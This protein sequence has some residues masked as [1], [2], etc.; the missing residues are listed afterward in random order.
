M[1]ALRMAYSIFKDKKYLDFYKKIEHYCEE[2]FVDSQ[3]GEWYG[4]LH[5]DNTVST[6]LK[7]NI[8]K[9]PFHVPRMYM[10]MCELDETGTI[11][12]YVK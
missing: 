7:G 2:C 9:G 8:F 10:I 1:I 3:Y 11:D 5:Y 4:Y 6:T 12:K